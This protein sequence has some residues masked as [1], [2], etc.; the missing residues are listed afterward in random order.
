MTIAAKHFDPVIGV[1]VHIIQP[2]GPVPPVPIPHPFVGFVIDPI[3]YAPVI[4]AS[5][6]VNGLKRA[7][8]GSSVKPTPPHIPIGGTF[9]KPPGNEGEVFMGS[10]TV[11][12]DGDAFSFLGVPVLT[13]QDIGMPPPPRSKKKSKIVSMVLPT[14][15][16]LAIPMG[17]LVT[18]GG[19]PTIS[20]MALGMRAGMAALGAALRKIKKLRKGPR[21]PSKW[22]QCS[23][24]IHE[25]ADDLLKKLRLGPQAR[26]RVHRAIC[27]VTGH[28]IDVAT[29]KVFTEFVDL[30]IPGPIPLKL[31]RVYFSTAHAVAGPLGHG[32]SHSFDQALLVG[33]RDVVIRL[34]D[35]RGVAFPRLRV[36]SSAFNR[37]EGLTLL[38]EDSGYV[39]VTKDRL[40]HR[41]G[42][43]FQDGVQR[44]SSIEDSVGHRIE[45]AYDPLGRL[46]AIV[47]SAHRRFELELDEHG[48]VRRLLGP[49]PSEKDRRVELRSYHYDRAGDLVEARDALGARWRFSYRDHLLIQECNRTGLSFYFEYDSPGDDARCVRTWGDG[50]IY[51]HKVTY[52]EGSTSVV[53]SHGA[54]TKYRHERGLVVERTDALGGAW[55]TTYDDDALMLGEANPL[56]E[57]TRQEYDELGNLVQRVDPDGARITFE[58]EDGLPVRVFD[59]MGGEWIHKFDAHGRMVERTD[60]CGA[61]TR[62]IYDAQLV[63]IL[64]AGGGKSRLRYDSGRNVSEIMAPDGTSTTWVHD[65]LGRLLKATSAGRTETRTVD[66]EGRVT[67]RILPDGNAE[68]RELDGE[69]RVVRLRDD[70]QD[71]RFEYAALGSITAR[72]QGAHRVEFRYDKE[73]RLIAVRNEA[74]AVQRF[75]LSATGELVEEIGFDGGVRRYERDPVGRPMKVTRPSGL[76]SS[77]ERDKS[78]RISRVVHSDG[79]E[80][81]YQY[82]ADGHLVRA[83]NRSVIV[84]LDRDARG[85]VIEELQGGFRVTSTYDAAGNRVRVDS[86]LGAAVEYSHNIMGDMMGVRTSDGRWQASFE[87]DM[88]GLEV[89]RDMPGVRVRWSRDTVGRP[90]EHH[91]WAAEGTH[92]SRRYTWET[93]DRLRAIDDSLRGRTTYGHDDRGYLTSARLPDGTIGLRIPDP[94]GNLFRTE[95]RSDRLYG[96]AGNLLEARSPEGTTRYEYDADGNLVRKREPGGGVWHYAWD[97]AGMLCQVTRP[98]GRVVE[99]EYDAFARRISKSFGGRKTRWVWDG[100]VPLHEWS[101]RH[102][103]STAAKAAPLVAVD[104]EAGR[105][106]LDANLARAQSLDQGTAEAP[107]LWLF[108]A[109]RFAPLAKVVNGREYAIVTDELGVPL[110]V[111]DEVG[112]AV[113]SGTLDAFGELRTVT[114][115]RSACPFRWPGQYEDSETGLYYNRYRYYD[116]QSGEFISRDPVGLAGG[117]ALYGYPPDPLTWADPSGLT[118][119]PKCGNAAGGVHGNSRLSTRAQHGYEI[120][121]TTTGEVVKTGVSGGART[122]SGG[123]VRANRQAN[124]WNREAGQAGRYEPRVVQEVPAGPGAREQI[125]QWEAENAARLREAGQLRDPTRHTRP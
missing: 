88:L 34:G 78:G 96:P 112:R 23:D 66:L 106:Q 39:L 76:Q 15:V 58:F 21:R 49:N 103:Q 36:G 74:G 99:L 17:G 109:E 20:V 114:G 12:A 94:A 90:V 101:E 46:I 68:Q 110:S 108:E 27:T 52:S 40:L 14:S 64:H 115:A 31:E 124:A 6:E 77:F 13:C 70:H 62:F 60:P 111:M 19:P 44:L 54:V 38:H 100:D 59:A 119:L 91:I 9:V 107:I 67:R 43:P 95:D 55:V 102:E 83:E 3:D 11:S 80:E 25:V 16:L 50:G 63:A 73:Q 71:I 61:T 104:L 97:A 89:G 42:V 87:R 35:G 57:E 41:Y 116:P 84:E 7:Q 10:A 122:A 125:L 75:G 4:G 24:R 33:Q 123:S 98:D 120:V 53:D 30:D 2:P 5:V 32:W 82:R 51:D 85:R 37:K 86:C 48:R 117:L 113:W 22:K 29:G 47:D 65:R 118:G 121:D 105:G 81:R 93:N 28:P 79:T 69:G 45:L 56:G 92:L 8:A 1:D 72:V 18:V 26:Q